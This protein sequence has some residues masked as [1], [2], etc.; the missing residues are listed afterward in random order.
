[1]EAG[2]KTGYIYSQ[3]DL[4]IAATALH[5]DLTVVTRNT[6]DFAR[7]GVSLVDPWTVRAGPE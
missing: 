5:H 1:L 7:V 6:N 4:I 3:P 2:R